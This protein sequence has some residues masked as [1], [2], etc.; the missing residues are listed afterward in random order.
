M[1]CAKNA[2]IVRD[3]EASGFP[4]TYWA[5][6]KWACPVCGAEIVTGFSSKGHAEDIAQELGWT[7]HDFDAG[8]EALE[9]H[10]H[11]SETSQS[12]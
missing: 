8:T 5:A 10:Y 7:D 11:R 3:P 12:A 9:F 4:S 6:D 1:R 2:F